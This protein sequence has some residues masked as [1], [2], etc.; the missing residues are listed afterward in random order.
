MGAT[1]TRVASPAKILAV[2]IALVVA[3]AFI[4]SAAQAAS[5]TVKSQEFS[6][7]TSVIEKKATSVKKGTTKLT[8]KSGQGYLKFKATKTKKYKFTFSNVK[9]QSGSSAFVEVQRPDASSPKY[10]FMTD[11]KTKGGKN[12]ALWLSQNGYKYNSG[13]LVNRN[14]PSRSATIKLKKGQ[15][16]YFYFY[17][18]SGKTKAKLKIK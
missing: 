4:P 14:L 2:L 17:S 5:K 6:T 11:V 8:F 12:S 3:L 15:K 16:V 9:S 10:S 1:T 18:S 7:K 13:K